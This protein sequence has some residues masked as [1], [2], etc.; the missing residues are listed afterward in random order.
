MTRHFFMCLFMLPTQSL[1]ILFVWNCLKL[2]TSC[3]FIFL[4]LI[5]KILYIHQTHAAAA[6]NAS[7]ISSNE[8]TR[9]KRMYALCPPKFQRIG[10]ECYFISH[11]KKNWLDA[12]FEC[13]D[14]RSKLAEPLKYEDR[15]IR[16]YLLQFDQGKRIVT[17]K[18]LT[19]I[20]FIIIRS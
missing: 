18:N 2:N 6:P 10:N 12:H 9:L 1:S 11:Y 5:L 13:K 19:L 4:V 8:R 17:K 7:E 16:K 3:L 20:F 15:R 14:R